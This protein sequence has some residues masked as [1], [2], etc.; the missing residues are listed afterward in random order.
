MPRIQ[1]ERLN[2]NLRDLTVLKAL[3]KD[4]YFL[5]LKHVSS[6][7]GDLSPDEVED[8]LKKRYSYS[9]GKPLLKVLVEDFK[10]LKQ[11]L[12]L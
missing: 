12:G 4:G 8:I 10:K 1:V 6:I 2:K 5:K 9:K 7:D 11:R 3:N